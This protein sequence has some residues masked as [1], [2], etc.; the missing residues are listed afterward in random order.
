MKQEVG[1]QLGE[2]YQGSLFRSASDYVAVECGRRC[3]L[4]A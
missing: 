2:N 1:Q 3:C 4:S